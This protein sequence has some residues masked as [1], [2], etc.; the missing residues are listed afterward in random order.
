MAAKKIVFGT[1]ARSSIREGVRK[2]SAAVKITLGPCGR[3]VVLEKSFGS[4]TVTKD[5]LGFLVDRVPAS[6][7]AQALT[8]RQREVLQLIAEG[9]TNKA[10]AD[11]LNISPRT[12]ETHRYTIMQEL[13]LH[14]TA[15]LTRFAIRHGIVS[16]E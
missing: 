3:N 16:A 9:S 6:N 13:D 1:D 5:V 7:R 11:A 8:A 4:P 10:I 12:A 14:T 2:L 15:D